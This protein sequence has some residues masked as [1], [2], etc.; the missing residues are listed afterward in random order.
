MKYSLLALGAALAASAAVKD[1]D[2]QVTPSTMM[3]GAQ[4]RNVEIDATAR[5]DYDSN[6]AKEGAAEAA[7]QGLTLGDVIYT[8]TV[9]IDATLPIGRQALFVQGSASYLFHQNNTQLNHDQYNVTAGVG[10]VLGPCA[11]TESGSFASGRTQITD[12]RAVDDVENVLTTVGGAVSA[13]CSRPTGLG[14]V[15]NARYQS[16]TNSASEVISSDFETVSASAGLSYARPTLGKL[17]I[18]GTYAKGDYPNR[19]ATLQSPGYESVGATVEYQRQLGGKIQ[20]VGSVGFNDV[21]PEEAPGSMIT[22]GHFQGLIYSF[23]GSYRVSSR[24]SADLSLNRSVSPTLI[25]GRSFEIQSA[26]AGDVVYKFGSRITAR[27]GVQENDITAE[28]GVAIDP[29]LSLTDS[30]LTVILVNL[31]YRQSQKLTFTLNAQHEQRTSDNQRLDYSGYRVGVSAGVS[32]LANGTRHAKSSISRLYRPRHRLGG[33]AMRH[34]PGATRR[35]PL[36]GCA[37]GKAPG[38]GR[39]GRNPGALGGTGRGG[40]D[41]G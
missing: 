21:T 2:A 4:E 36:D 27:L 14:V 8:P 15:A 23:V 17:M 40:Q 22:G 12:T 34:G 32:F 38:A 31:S 7:L 30:K 29:I 26:Y 10:N 24:L 11:T 6:V 35:D 3:S 41:R 5:V 25:A 13:I 39:H 37:T 19:A 9:L 28:G 20:L 33:P 1:A 18:E 16:G